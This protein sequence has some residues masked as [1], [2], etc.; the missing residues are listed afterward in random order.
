M[1]WRWVALIRGGTPAHQLPTSVI[2]RVFFVSTFVGTFL[3][4]SI[5][6]DAVRAY[7][8]A[9]HSVR[10]ADSVAS[11][12]MD[13]LLGV[14]SL[15]A[16]AVA[17]L[18]LARDLSREPVVQ[19]SL[20]VTAAGC[21]AGI[22]A[23][24]SETAARLAGRGARLLPSHRLSRMGE[25][26]VLAIRSYRSRHATLAGVLA[27][28]IAVQ[29]L[30]VAQ[31]YALGRALGITAGWETYAGLVPIVLLVMLLPISVFGLGTSQWAFDTLF[32]R[33]GATSADAVALSF[34]FL[35]LGVLGNL[36][37]ALL[38]VTKRVT[39]AGSQA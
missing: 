17:G 32:T 12:L 28:S 3:P 26:L 27:A 21:I 10:G 6:S 24:Y 20:A 1:A 18:A 16:V 39:P 34:L 31:A 13:R 36:P 23:V 38:Y 30:R 4:A 33:A 35:G 15:L 25:A 5:G 22:V 14:L 7:G 37:G 19:W 9:R 2:L 11:V 29:G 8:L